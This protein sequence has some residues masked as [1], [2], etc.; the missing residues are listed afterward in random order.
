MPAT[1]R[2]PGRIFINY[3]RDD[4]GGAAGRLSDSLERYFGPHRVFRDVGGIEAGAD[5]EDVLHNTAQ[6]ADAMIVLIGRQWTRVAGDDGRARLHDPNDWVAREITA[7]IERKI[8]IYPVLVESAVMPRAEELPAALK[9]LTR[10]NAISISDQRWALDVTRLARIVAI[11]IP[12]SR[13]ERTLIAVQWVVSLALT[14]AIVVPALLVM[15]D[16]VQ[17]RA[18]EH[19]LYSRAVSGVPFVVI[20]ACVVLLLFHARLVDAGARRWVHVAAA[21]GLVGTLAAFLWAGLGTPQGIEY[22]KLPL[23]MFFGSTATAAS[24][25]AL[26][27]LSRFKAR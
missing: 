25:L 24:M 26:M 17:G 4:T 12:G 23:A 22:P 3:R 8:P 27:N 6:A 18:A 10:Y 11:D 20:S 21:A 7:A 16:E 9:P 13:A 2:A 15:L 19:A 1:R 5:F 14:L